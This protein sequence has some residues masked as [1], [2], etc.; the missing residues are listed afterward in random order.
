MICWASLALLSRFSVFHQSA[1]RVRKVSQGAIDGISRRS[2]D[3][4]N[5]R[6]KSMWKWSGDI[7]L[8]AGLIAGGIIVGLRRHQPSIG[9]SNAETWALPEFYYAEQGIAGNEDVFITGTLMGD[10]VGYPV[11]TMNISC[12]ESEGK[13]T[14]ASAQEIGRRQLGTITVDDWPVVSWTPTTIVAKSAVGP[15]TDCFRNTIT[16]NRQSKAVR[17]MEEPQNS[18]SDFCTKGRKLMGPATV[19]DWRIGNPR[20][21]WGAYL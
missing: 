18:D 17:Y 2:E 13:C 5:E 19:E 16:V 6:G 20:Q 12:Y 21:P 7:I 4:A 9:P 1:Q 8:S 15:T 10:D 11:N 3:A 14:V